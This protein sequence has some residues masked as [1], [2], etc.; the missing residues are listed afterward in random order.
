MSIAIAFAISLGTTA[1][2]MT[3]DPNQW[4]EDLNGPEVM[5]WVEK[6]NAKTLQVL[7]SDARYPTLF[8][9][10]VSIAEAADRV[11]YPTQLDGR[12]FNFWRDTEHPQGIWRYTTAESYATATPEW[13]TILD[14]DALSKTEG[15]KWVWEGAI[16]LPSDERRCL[17]QLSDGGE[18]AVSV[19]EFDLTTGT[20]VDGG[21]SLPTSKQTVDWLDADTVVIARDWGEGTLTASSYPYVIKSL[22]RG[23]TLDVAKELYRGTADDIAAMPQMFDIADGQRLAIA[24]RAR[25]FFEFDYWLLAGEKP[26]QLSLPAK[27]SLSGV[28]AGQLILRTSED[29]DSAGAHIPAGSVA[30]VAVDDLL[31]GKPLKPVLIVA[32]AN[33]QSIENVATTRRHVVAVLNDNVRGRGYV[34]TPGPDGWSSQRLELPDNASIDILDVTRASDAAFLTVTGFLDPTTLWSLDAD[35]AAVRKEKALP[36]RFDPRG[37]AVQQLEAKSSD[38]TLIPYFIVRPKDAPLDGSTPTLLNAYGGFEVSM[39]PRYLMTTGK[40]WV[41]Q[42]N[43]FVLANIRGGGEF[44]P[45]WHE[46]GRKTKRQIIYDDFAAVAQDLIRRKLTSPQHLG[47]VGGSNGGLLMGVEIN[48]HPELFSAVCIQVPLLD[49]LRYEQIQAGASWVDEYGSVSVPEEK[50][51]L[52]TISPYQNLRKDGEYPVP[53][54]VTT[55]KDDRVGP[56]HARKFAARM[57]QYGLPYLFFEDTAG[58]HSGDADVKQRA[59]LLALEMTYYYRQLVDGPV[60]ATAEAR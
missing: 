1:A 14:L 20:F 18:D 56:Q 51:F 22:K 23:Q 48:Q 34:Y 15:R 52:E 39:T 2:A 54:L 53:F 46:A 45:A 10:A 8:A 33:R 37:L 36:D 26:R 19:R 27:S 60:E 7:E 11:P 21:F 6:E 3:P 4:L 49:M 13:S 31:T 9:Q 25:T 16:C 55:T 57:Q 42:G 40:L 44:G 59:R 29:W 12:I 17:L 5:A 35:E 41:E 28:V 30:A 24:L 50:A 43:A 38:G 58:G 47:I 32:P